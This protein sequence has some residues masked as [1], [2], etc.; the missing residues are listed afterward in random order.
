[1]SSWAKLSP[2]NAEAFQD[3][4]H[5]IRFPL[6]KPEF[7]DQ[8]VKTS[9]LLKKGNS[10][11]EKF[12]K[13]LRRNSYRA[14]SL[15]FR[16]EKFRLPHELVFAVGGFGSEALSAVEARTILKSSNLNVIL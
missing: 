14:H 11:I 16:T 12:E 9:E 15:R 2:E 10:H 5:Y 6:L 7:F 8:V 4:V 13:S 3:L 1:M